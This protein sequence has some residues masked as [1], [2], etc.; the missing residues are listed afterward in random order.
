MDIHIVKF[1]DNLWLKTLQKV[2]HDIYHLP[3]YFCL[4]ST[5]SKTIPEA[6]LIQEGDKI[7]FVPYLL[8]KCDDI[9]IDELI[10]PEIF[11]I[12]SPYGYTG[13]LLSDEAEASPEFVNSAMNELKQTLKV[14]GI[15]SAFLRLHPIINSNFE[16]ICETNNLTISGKTISIDL[17]LSELEIWSDTKADRRNKINK[18]KRHGLTARM[19]PFNEYIRE[20]VDIYEETMARVDARKLYLEFGYDYCKQFQQLLGDYLY[21]CIVEFEDKVAS[22]GLYSEYGGIIQALFGGTRD[23]FFKLSPSSLETDYVRFWAKE[24][25]NK[26]LH[27]GGGLGGT[28]NS[29]YDF[30]SS[31]SKL[32]HNLITMRLIIDEE[33]YNYLVNTRANN[34]NISPTKLLDSNFF[35]AYRSEYNADDF[36][37]DFRSNSLPI[38]SEGVTN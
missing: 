4:E 27:L 2:K 20:F 8:R 38:N 19:V 14:R 28:K 6:V 11:D 25:G 18:C 21:L 36:D 32:H 31:F 13:V 33:K 30:K 37:A 12:V 35:P 24:R 15:C 9:L 10:K 29:L 3:E 34:L 22:T 7:L 17:T 23:E 1:S 16:E 5:R 26:L